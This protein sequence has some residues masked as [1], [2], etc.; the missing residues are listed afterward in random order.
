M[1]WIEGV[2]CDITYYQLV[3][4]NYVLNDTW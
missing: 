4:Y 3:L 1:H 2:V